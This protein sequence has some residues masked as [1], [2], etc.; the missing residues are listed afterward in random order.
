MSSMLCIWISLY[1]AFGI[2]RK[3]KRNDH[4]RV[5]LKEFLLVR[6]NDFCVFGRAQDLWNF[7]LLK[8][9]FKTPA[10]RTQSVR[11]ANAAVA[12]AIKVKSNER[13]NIVG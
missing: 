10:K 8:P 12:V 7:S 4:R 13:T 3:V 1:R 6:S 2:H 5:T 11:V 9:S